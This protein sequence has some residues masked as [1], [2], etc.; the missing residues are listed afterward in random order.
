MFFEPYDLSIH[1]NK[2]GIVAQFCKIE[3]PSRNQCFCG[4]GINNKCSD[5][6]CVSVCVCVCVF[7][8]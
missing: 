3:T 4:K 5:C 7:I 2:K 6:V 1:E 8:P